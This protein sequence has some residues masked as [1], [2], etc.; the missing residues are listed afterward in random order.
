MISAKSIKHREIRL[1]PW[2]E[3]V[4]TLL[5]LEIGESKVSVVLSLGTRHVKLSFPK[6]SMESRTLQRDLSSCKPGTKIALM[7]TNEASRPLLVR[8]VGRETQFS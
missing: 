1:M 5:G 2:S 7:K 8:L 4:G 3:C 6:E